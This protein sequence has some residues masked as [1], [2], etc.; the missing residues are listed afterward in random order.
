VLLSG[1]GVQK[2]YQAG[3]FKRLLD[4]RLRRNDGKWAFMTFFNTHLAQVID[5]V[6]Q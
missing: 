6:V 3:E 1:A 2:K 4:S 5:L